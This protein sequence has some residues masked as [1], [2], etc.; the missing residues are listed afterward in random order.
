MF[1]VGGQPLDDLGHLLI[2]VY[3]ETLLLGDTG[4][5]DVLCIKL[6]LHD[7]LESFEHQ[8]LGICDGERLSWGSVDC[9]QDKDTQ[10]EG[11]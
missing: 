11:R 8:S 6:L 4:Q 10:E 1:S 3:S 7:L 2:C 5:L 9:L